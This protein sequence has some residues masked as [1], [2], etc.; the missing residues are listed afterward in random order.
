MLGRYSCSPL[1]DSILAE[2]FE[3]RQEQVKPEA[4]LGKVVLIQ[5][6]RI[7]CTELVRSGL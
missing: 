7:V 4:K 2:D 3:M 5:L 1:D 6:F